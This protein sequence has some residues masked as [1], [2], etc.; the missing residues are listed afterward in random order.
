MFDSFDAIDQFVIYRSLLDSVC[1]NSGHGFH[2]GDQGHPAY[3]TGAQGELLSF[4]AIGDHPDHNHLYK[5]MRELSEA[6]KDH[7][8]LRRPDLVLSW[9]EFCRI[10]VDSYDAAHK[11]V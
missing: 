2:N 1:A 5:M 3:R 10:A 11:K 9:Q 7:P 8:E 6:L 4:G